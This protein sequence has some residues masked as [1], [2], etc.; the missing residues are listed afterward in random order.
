MFSV[1]FF[2]LYVL[3]AEKYLLSFYPG[4]LVCSTKASK[5]VDSSVFFG[6]CERFSSV[7]SSSKDMRISAYNAETSMSPRRI[8]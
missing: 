8:D 2:L 3:H 6:S 7:G 5:K 1:N 4:Y